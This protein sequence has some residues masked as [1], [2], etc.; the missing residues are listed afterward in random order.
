[1]PG[2]RTGILKRVQL[3]IGFPTRKLSET[4]HETP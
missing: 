4:S 3:P 1:L 2:G